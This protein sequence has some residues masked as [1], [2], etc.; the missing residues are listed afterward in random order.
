MPSSKTCPVPIPEER[1]CLF[2]AAVPT[3]TLHVVPGGLGR[4]GQRQAQQGLHVLLPARRAA[5]R[6]LHGRAVCTGAAA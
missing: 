2:L 1:L 5:R 3:D 6:P 4:L